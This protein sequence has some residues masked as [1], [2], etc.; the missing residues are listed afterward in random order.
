VH[1]CFACSSSHR[2]RSCGT[3]EAAMVV[4]FAISV[5]LMA[6]FLKGL[7]RNMQ[8][9]SFKELQGLQ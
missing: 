3:P 8:E 2:T 4:V 6:E 5:L 1:F 9:N 7:S